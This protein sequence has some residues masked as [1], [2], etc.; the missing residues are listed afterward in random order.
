[1]TRRHR[2]LGPWTCSRVRLSRR[3]S[4]R[5][6]MVR[7]SMAGPSYDTITTIDT[8]PDPCGRT[9]DG[10]AR[11]PT[12]Q[13]APDES[14]GQPL[15][16]GCPSV[17]RPSETAQ[18]TSQEL[19]RAADLAWFVRV[20]GRG[21]MWD[22]VFGCGVFG[23]ALSKSA[24]RR[25]SSSPQHHDDHGHRRSRSSRRPSSPVMLRSPRRRRPPSGRR[26]RCERD[27]PARCCQTIIAATHTRYQRR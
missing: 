27:S 24:A 15:A 26:R 7:T 11:N 6:K 12:L 3:R 17:N 22:L 10:Q 5:R 8:L 23:S 25:I 19:R 9:K 16:D 14:E 2:E 21:A 13:R 20:V 18:G 4:W 1:M